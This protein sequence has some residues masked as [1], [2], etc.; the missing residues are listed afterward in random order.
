MKAFFTRV[1]ISDVTVDDN[2]FTSFKEFIT[3]FKEFINSMMSLL[4]VI[5]P[6]FTDEEIELVITFLLIFFGLL[7]Y[8]L[9]R[10]VTI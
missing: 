9:G 10:K 5:F 6:F 3:G 4:R 1:L 8:L 2:W 7:V